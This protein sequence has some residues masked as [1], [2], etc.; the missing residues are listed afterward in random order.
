MPH[1]NGQLCQDHVE[2]TSDKL[3]QVFTSICMWMGHMTQA[4][5]TPVDVHNQR[6]ETD[7]SSE[8]LVFY[9]CRGPHKLE[10]TF[11][12][13]SIRNTCEMSFW[14]REDQNT[15]SYILSVHTKTIQTI[16]VSKI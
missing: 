10:K 6:F 9:M 12:G 1:T 2:G 15:T 14:C 3:H 8:R 4:P 11:A 16:T 7:V 13:E 5:G